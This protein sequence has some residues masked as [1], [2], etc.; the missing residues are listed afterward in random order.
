MKKILSLLS[1]VLAAFALLV[2][3]NK[4]NTEIPGGDQGEAPENPAG[5]LISI[6]V[7]FSEGLSRVSF[8][9]LM[10]EDGKI[11]AMDP[12]WE[13]TDKLLIA[14]KNDPTDNVTFNIVPASISA[15]GKMATFT[16]ESLPSADEFA[17]SVVDGKSESYATQ[18]QPEDGVFNGKYAA[19]ASVPAADIHSFTLDHASGVIA[20][21]V[22]MP[23]TEVA[24]DVMLIDITASGNIFYGGNTLT[25]RF[26]SAGDAGGD[27]VL[28]FFAALPAEIE[29]SEATSLLVHINAPGATHDVYTRYLEIPA[30]KTF[31]VGSVNNININAVNSG[32]YANASTTNIGTSTNP[33]LIGDQYQMDAMHQLM[34]RGAK[35]YFKLIDDI[36]MTGIVWFPLNNGYPESGGTKYTGNVY[37]KQ[38]DFNGNNKTISNLSTKSSGLTSS[39]EYAS[40]FGVLMGDVYDLAIE[41]ATVTSQG[42]SGIIAGYVGTGS[43]GPSHCEVRNVSIYESI[44]NSTAST[45][46][47]I[48]CGQSAKS[49]NVFSDI[50]VE[51]CVVSSVGY[52]AGL[53]AYFA[54][55]ATV[56]DIEIYDTDITSSGNVNSKDIPEDGFAGGIA[57]RVNAAVDFDRCYIEGGTITGP[58]QANNDNSKKSRFVG[59]LVAYVGNVAATFDDC[60]VVDVA[61]GL[62]SAPA[63]NNGRYVGGAFGY[64]GAAAVVGNST[65]CSVDGI[66]MNNN[67]RNYIGGFVSYLDG[68]TVKNS[69]AGSSAAIGNA[70]YS[71]A[72]GGFV[73]YANGGTLYNNSTSV[74]VQGAGNPG[75]FVGWVETTAATF[76]KCSA[77]GDVTAGGNNAGGFCGI[78]KIGATYTECSSSGTV[79]STAGYVGGLIGYINADG[80]TISKCYSTSTVTAGNYVGG[81]VGV[82]ETDTI[83]KS[84]YN[85]TVTGLSRVGGILG[86]GLRDDATTIKNCYSRGAVIGGASEQRF[87]GIV[88]DLGKGGKVENCWSDATVNAGRVLGGIVGLACYQTWGDATASNNTISGCIAWNPEVKA[89][90]LG[91]FGS[92]GAVI[93]H[94]SFKNVFGNC[95]RRSDM[96]YANSY[97]C[98]GGE[99]NTTCVDQPDCNGANWAKGTTP[100]TKSGYTYQQPYYGVA[101]DPASNT[102]SSIARDIIGWSSDVWDFT[103]DLPTLK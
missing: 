72:G 30:G 86:I 74:S 6:T 41:N 73:G 61:L 62:A 25:L 15:D 71:G 26:A 103:G 67:V 75:G 10:D 45:Y 59:G 42:K 91:N 24:A 46:C 37:D 8:D 13:T 14:A 49:G 48:L 96:D 18:T 77:S 39:D 101:K 82:A 36:D 93:G 50:Y 52:A 76:E 16:G 12:S 69:T 23:S 80:A 68:A 20:F 5:E 102:V 60:E 65:G 95:Y 85:G 64:L 90:Q 31:E 89:A 78:D 38:L 70:T 2:A 66:T 58:T 44:L 17:I 35:K 54:N 47:G 97:N 63:T 53:V 7:S 100:G 11:T 43:Y 21:T 98:S 94:T 27:G 9:A 79:S 99:W 56:R 51:N 87:G 22:K 33:Y 28:H 32:L 19:T 88:G 29:I 4:N 84:Y 40:I 92:S 83:E 57:A 1:G 81:L 34:E 3:C 55:P